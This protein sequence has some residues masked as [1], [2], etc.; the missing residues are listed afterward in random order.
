M[1]YSEELLDDILNNEEREEA[2]EYYE[3]LRNQRDHDL[4]VYNGLVEE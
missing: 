3:D 2:D 1:T 4:D